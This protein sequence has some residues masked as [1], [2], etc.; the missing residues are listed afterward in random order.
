MLL[1]LDTENKSVA[2]N[3]S[4]I[5]E[6]VFELFSDASEYGWIVQ[7]HRRVARKESRTLWLEFQINYIYTHRHTHDTEGQ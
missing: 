4:D 1:T 5:G 6:H 2:G 7:E 3:L